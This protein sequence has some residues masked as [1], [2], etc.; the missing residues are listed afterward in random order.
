MGSGVPRWWLVS[1]I[2]HPNYLGFHDPIWRFA[3]VSNGL[4]KNHQLEY[5]FWSKKIITNWITKG[6]PA[7]FFQKKKQM[8]RKKGSGCYPDT[9]GW[10]LHLWEMDLR[11]W[12]Q[13]GWGVVSCRYSGFTA[14]KTNSL[15]AGNRSL[16]KKQVFGPMVW[17]PVAGTKNGNFGRQ[18]EVTKKKLKN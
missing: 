12:Y 10:C 16:A 9:E 13:K 3:Y 18:L 2:F 4:V 7:C 17:S 5:D 6:R 14:E 15:T 1:N 8:A 11:V